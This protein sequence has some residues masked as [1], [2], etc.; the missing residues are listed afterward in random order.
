MTSNKYEINKSYLLIEKFSEVPAHL[1]EQTTSTT[2]YDAV[3]R[4][5]SV[6]VSECE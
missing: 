2:L 3:W 1:F 6:G 4:C 5:V